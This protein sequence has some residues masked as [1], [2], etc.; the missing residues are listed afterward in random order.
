MIA[1]RVASF[2]ATISCR[3]R[4]G[5]ACAFFLS[6]QIVGNVALVCH[7]EQKFSQVMNGH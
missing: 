2:S 4:S 5:R 7:M 3:D 1:E 6:I